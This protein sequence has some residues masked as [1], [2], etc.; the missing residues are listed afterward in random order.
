MLGVAAVAAVPGD[1]AAVVAVPDDVVVAVAVVVVDVA[2]AAVPAAT[3]SEIASA[4]I[5]VLLQ[6]MEH[7][8]A[9]LNILQDSLKYHEGLS[10]QRHL[11]PE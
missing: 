11:A 3:Q 1:V 2:A 9:G 10:V 4:Q 5:A 8:G 6:K 7:Q